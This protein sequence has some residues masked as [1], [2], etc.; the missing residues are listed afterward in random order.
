M[1]LPTKLQTTEDWYLYVN[2][3]YKRINEDEV[4]IIEQQN[5]I[6]ALER[7]IIEWKAYLPDH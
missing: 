3:L 6:N 1:A 2:E 4:T 7:Q 5:K